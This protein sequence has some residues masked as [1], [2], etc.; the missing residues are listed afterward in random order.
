[1]SAAPGWQVLGCWAMTNLVTNVENQHKVSCDAA[2]RVACLIASYPDTLIPS[3]RVSPFPRPLA[4]LSALCPP[5]FLCCGM[6]TKRAGGG[7]RWQEVVVTT[8]TAAM[9]AHVDSAS[10]LEQGCRALCNLAYHSGNTEAI[11]SHGGACHPLEL[12]YTIRG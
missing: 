7:S 1:M 4:P 10:V 8:I 6:H 9:I 3:F 5:L 11:A 2:K 12:Q